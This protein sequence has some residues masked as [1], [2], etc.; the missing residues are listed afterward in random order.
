MTHQLTIWPSNIS[1]TPDTPPPTEEQSY[2]KVE[3]TPLTLKELPASECP[4]HRLNHL[5][6]GALS[7]TE[8]LAILL[9]NA[10]QLQDAANLLATFENLVGL[11]RAPTTELQQ[12]PGVGAAT[13]ARI[14]AAL[15]LG[16][17]LTQERNHAATVRSP[18]DAA[19][20]L[21]PEM[22][23]LEQEHLRVILLDTKNRVMAI[24]TVY[25]GSVNT[26]M[27]RVSELFREAIRR[28]CPAI[29]LAHNHPST[30]CSPSPEDILV[31]RQAVE[32]GRLLDIEILDHLILGGSTQYVSLKEKGLGFS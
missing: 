4:V 28:N 19:N 30:D 24:P 17:R 1:T 21:L 32:A 15:E 22:G 31:T 25:I 27:I 23:L 5:G 2:R 14:K 20:L 11:T 6:A 16:V 3:R 8:L 10:H 7:T 12:Q 29:I 13:A 26:T 18:A 9:G